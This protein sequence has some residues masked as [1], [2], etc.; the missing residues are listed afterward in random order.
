MCALGDAEDGEYW[1]HP[2]TWHGYIFQ[3]GK[4]HTLEDLRNLFENSDSYSPFFNKGKAGPYRLDA[5]PSNFVALD[6]K[7][8]DP[9]SPK[10]WMASSVDFGIDDQLGWITGRVDASETNVAFMNL[11]IANAGPVECFDVDTID[12]LWLSDL[13]AYREEE[14]GDEQV[15]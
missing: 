3:D 5:Y 8:L 10:V 7:V 15:M 14:W 11:D 13:S 1:G 2:F 6:E 4:P 12:K 9:D